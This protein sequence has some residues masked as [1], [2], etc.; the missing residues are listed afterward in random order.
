[1]D[2]SAHLFR[3]SQLMLRL[4]TSSEFAGPASSMI[5]LQV[6]LLALVVHGYRLDG[7][8]ISLM[9]NNDLSQL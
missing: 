4:K 5:K 6:P 7:E 3:G 9:Q 2:L 1:M 8:Y